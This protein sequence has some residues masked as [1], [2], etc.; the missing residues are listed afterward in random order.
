MVMIY[1]LLK[2]P[3]TFIFFRFYHQLQ[4]HISSIPSSSSTQNQKPLF[5][6]SSAQNHSSFLIVNQILTAILENRSFD[7]E[8]SS[9]IPNPQWTVGTVCEVLRSI[10]RYFFQSCESIGRQKGF[11]H[12]TPLKQ[13]NLKQESE[14]IE[15]GIHVLGPG[16]YRDPMKVKLGLD[17]ALEFYY[18]VETQYGFT[19]TEITCREMSIVLAKGNRLN[20][21]WDF[22]KEMERKSNGLLVTTTTVT[23]LIKVLG[24]EGLVNEALAA[25]YRMKQLHCRPDVYAYNTIIGA[26]CR[27]GKFRKARFLLEQMELPGFRCPPDTFTYTI[28]ISFYCKYSLQTSCKKAIR[29]RL[30]EANH[31]FRHM[32]FKGFTP[33]VVTYN[34][35]IDGCCKTY[36]IERA[37]ELFDDMLKKCYVPNRITYNSFIRYYSAVNE[38]DKAVEMMRKMKL[39]NHGKP[40]TSSYTP[41]IHALCEAGRVLEARDFL[42]EL[43]DGGS[44]PREY[45]AKLVRDALKSTGETV[46]EDELWRKIEEGIKIRYNQVMQVKPMMKQIL[47]SS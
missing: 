44:F 43:V 22:L 18:W 7:S 31:M 1:S 26:L 16:A 35:L 40:T 24:E 14:H 34:C 2:K 28:F 36:R 11:R 29:R 3:K 45:T 37:L 15:K 8:L 12:R 42:V 41:I 17:K 5:S 9:S 32:I 21:L 46:F 4:F 20:V 6:S 33:D 47:P 23:C 13:R 10:P 27:V 19:H 25:F 30:W 38:I 39:L